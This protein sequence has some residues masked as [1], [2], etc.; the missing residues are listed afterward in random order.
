MTTLAPESVKLSSDDVKALRAADR[1]I[2]RMESGSA[3]SSIE[4]V[5]CGSDAFGATERQRIIGARTRLGVWGDGAYGRT[6]DNASAYRAFAMIHTP[7][8]SEEWRTIAALIRAGDELTLEWQ[9]G[10]AESQV[11]RSAGLIG[12]MLRL[13]ISRGDRDMTF[14]VDVSVG[15]DNTAR[16]IRTN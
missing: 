5:K 11:I 6:P 12:D 13:I 7:Q 2:F 14:L 3:P 4:A 9:R 16:M 10:A 1:I 15:R 8:L